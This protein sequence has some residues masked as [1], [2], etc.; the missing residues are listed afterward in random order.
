MTTIGFTTAVSGRAVPLSITGPSFCSPS[1]LP[2]CGGVPPET[3]SHPPRDTTAT[4]TARTIGRAALDAFILSESAW[5]LA[6]F[7]VGVHCAADG[8]AA[9]RACRSP[10]IFP[11]QWIMLR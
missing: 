10:L 11:R 8:D 4:R 2:R 5:L 7:T 9:A 1:M 6:Y 3:P